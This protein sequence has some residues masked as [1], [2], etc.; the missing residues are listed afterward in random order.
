MI[1]FRENKTVKEGFRDE[2][3]DV[4]IDRFVVIDASTD[5]PVVLH[6]SNR[7]GS[8]VKLG[9]GAELG[10]SVICD[11]YVSV[12]SGSSVGASTQL[13]YGATVHQ[14]VSIGER[15][16]VAGDVGNWTVLEDDV[17]FMGRIVHRQNHPHDLNTWGSTPV[18]SP[19]VRSRAFI[20]ENAMLLGGITIGY[21]AYVDMG[22]LVRTDIPDEHVQIGGKIMPISQFRG[23]ISAK[24]AP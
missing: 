20:G 11:D 12:G 4:T 8:F 18:P 9:P 24:Q 5:Q 6:G 21:G 16:I 2:S 23:Y 1:K 3:N 13:L 17:T 19:I 14:D 7:L 15:C 10:S 22:E